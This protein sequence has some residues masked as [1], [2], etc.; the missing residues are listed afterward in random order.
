MIFTVVIAQDTDLCAHTGPG[1]DGDVP[2][3]QEL[4]ELI[5]GEFMAKE[6]GL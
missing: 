1:G 5:P 3:I 2:R 4:V 6:Y